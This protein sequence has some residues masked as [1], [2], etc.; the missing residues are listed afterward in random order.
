[1]KGDRRRDNRYKKSDD[2][3]VGITNVYVNVRDG[4]MWSSAR[5]V[6]SLAG[7]VEL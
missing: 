4:C 5:W 7:I 3:I 2:F 6:I 1:M